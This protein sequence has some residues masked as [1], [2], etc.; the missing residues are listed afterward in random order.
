MS[1]MTKYANKMLRANV[2]LP[3]QAVEGH[4]TAYR[5]DNQFESKRNGQ[6]PLYTN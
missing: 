6:A 3:M 2:G 1:M 5:L 4:M